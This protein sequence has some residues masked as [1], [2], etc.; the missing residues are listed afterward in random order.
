MSILTN[1]YVR[2]VGEATLAGIVAFGITYQAT[3]NWQAALIAAVLAATNKAAPPITGGKP[4]G[5]SK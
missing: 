2:L 5:A 3:G 1:H 4:T